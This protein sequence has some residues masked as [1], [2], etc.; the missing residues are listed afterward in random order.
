MRRTRFAA[1]TVFLLGGS[2][3]F[4]AQPYI[5][6]DASILAP[7]QCQFEVGKQVNRGDSELWMLPA[8]NLVANTEIT[9]GK[10]RFSEADGQRHLYVVQGKGVWREF[11]TD[12]TG[13][14]WVAGVAGH[15]RTEE[16]QRR[17]SGYYGFLLASRA[18]LNG[19]LTASANLGFIDSRDTRE[20]PAAWSAG[21]EYSL[22]ERLKVLGEFY[23]TDRTAPS[24]QAGLRFSLVPERVEIDVTAGGAAE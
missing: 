7:G 23:G 21:A 19:R 2:P 5:T 17:I 12:Q 3:G 10:S 6:D 20:T 24:S 16:D 1:L 14:G 4:A 15:S 11:S 8:C 9:V 18:F 22:N 13:F